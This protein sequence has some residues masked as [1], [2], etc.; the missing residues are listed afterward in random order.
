MGGLGSSHSQHVQHVGGREGGTEP[1]PGHSA[2]LDTREESTARSALPIARLCNLGVRTRRKRR[3][4]K[5]RKREGA[6]DTL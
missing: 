3:R 5:K 4:R 6:E 1:S 2:V